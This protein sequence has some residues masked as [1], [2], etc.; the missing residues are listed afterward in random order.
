[1][2]A[3]SRLIPALLP[4][5]LVACGDKDTGDEPDPVDDCEER[6]WFLD[7]DGDGDGADETLSACGARGALSF[8]LRQ[9]ISGYG[10]FT[11]H[12]PPGFLPNVIERVASVGLSL[13]HI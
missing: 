6:T 7:A 3:L 1:M 2:T 5:L 13:I 11:G 8:L 4:A 12:P 9:E 10:F